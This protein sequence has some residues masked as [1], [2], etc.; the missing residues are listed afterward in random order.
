MKRWL[1]CRL[2]DWYAHKSRQHMILSIFYQDRRLWVLD[3]LAQEDERGP[4]IYETETG[5]FER[6]MTDWMKR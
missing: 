4:D 5:A 6:R 3:R 2:R 1:L